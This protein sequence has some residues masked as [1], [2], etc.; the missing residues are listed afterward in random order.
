MSV[1]SMGSPAPVPST[2]AQADD[3]D[4]SATRWQPKARESLA[5]KLPGKD[6]NQGS[7]RFFNTGLTCRFF[8]KTG[9]FK[10]YG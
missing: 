6:K 3:L 7:H 9:F 4:V 5:D 2:S 1:D 10:I 8:S